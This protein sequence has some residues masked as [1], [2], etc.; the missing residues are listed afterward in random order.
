MDKRCADPK[1]NNQVGGRE[2]KTKLGDEQT[3]Y[4]F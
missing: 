4:S 1:R 3:W 2:T